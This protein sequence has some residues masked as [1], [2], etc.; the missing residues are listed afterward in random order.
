MQPGNITLALTGEPIG[1]LVH[2]KEAK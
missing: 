1:T 2:P